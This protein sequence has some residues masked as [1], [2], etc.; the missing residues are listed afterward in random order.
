MSMQTEQ[1]KKAL[2]LYSSA[3][4]KEK[5]QRQLARI[6]PRLEALFDLTVH[7]NE[8]MEE[9]VALARESCGV[10]DALILFGGDGSLNHIVSALA[11]KENAPIFGYLPGGT[12]KDGGKNL[13]AKSIEKGLRVI[14]QGH[15]A[16]L[17]LVKANGDY[18]M[19]VAGFGAYMDVSY[20]ARRRA[21]KALGRV[22]YYLLCIK[23]MFRIRHHE[24][25]IESDEGAFHGKVSVAAFL[26]GKW[27][28]GMKVNKRG[29][30]NDGRLEILL[31]RPRLFNGFLSFFFHAGFKRLYGSQIKVTI[32]NGVEWCLDGEKGPKGPLKMEVAQ[33]ALKAYCDPR[34]LD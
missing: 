10:Y 33:G 22:V 19:Y 16:K 5:K 2:F 30:L 14:E 26:N 15:V 11:E 32:D 20:V 28:G 7:Q 29:R 34:Q 24:I 18:F 1:K 9:G 3:T 23:E 17:D 13:G 21:K 4:G 6:L 27:L 31:V 12:L 25:D 8:T